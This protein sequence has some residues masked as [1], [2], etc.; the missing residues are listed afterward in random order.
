MPMKCVD[1][2]KT[3][4]DLDAV[5]LQVRELEEREKN[6]VAQI[7]VW[8]ERISKASQTERLIS[9]INKILFGATSDTVK[10]IRIEGVLAQSLK[11]ESTTV[12]PHC[13][14]LFGCDGKTC[15]RKEPLADKRVV[16]G[17]KIGPCS[18][19]PASLTQIACTGSFD[20]VECRKCQAFWDVPCC[21]G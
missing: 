5:L 3:L 1:C 6:R 10:V 7:D 11:R 9:E 8:V 4:A 21:H 16:S 18:C 12:C 15:A 14:A 13:G 2:E 19:S 17:S 20:S